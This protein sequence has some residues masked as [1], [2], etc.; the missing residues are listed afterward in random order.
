MTNVTIV[1]SKRDKISSC[2]WSTYAEKRPFVTLSRR[3]LWFLPRVEKL[4]RFRRDSLEGIKWLYYYYIVPCYYMPVSPETYRKNVT[5]VTKLRNSQS[6]RHLR[7]YELSRRVTF[8]REA[9]RDTNVTDDFE[10]IVSNATKIHHT[11]K[12]LSCGSEKSEYLADP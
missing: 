3:A 6:V 10:N 2:I 7:Q 11:P 1:T 8:S 5:N 4:S 9:K 12:G